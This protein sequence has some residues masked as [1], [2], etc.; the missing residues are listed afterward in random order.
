MRIISPFYRVKRAFNIASHMAI[1]TP[2]SSILK[3]FLK[4]V[5]FLYKAAEI[6]MSIRRFGKKD[7][8]YIHQ[9]WLRLKAALLTY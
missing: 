8:C 3:L 4:C 1:F 6:Y 2:V 9:L 7:V 5:A